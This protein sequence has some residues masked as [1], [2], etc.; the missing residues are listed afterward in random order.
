MN[1]IGERNGSSGQLGASWDVSNFDNWTSSDFPLGAAVL[2]AGNSL[3]YKTGGWRSDRPVWNAADCT[4]CM[5]CWVHCA[6]S[7]ILVAEQQMLGIDYDH[8]KGCGICALECRF[9]ALR[10]LPEAEAA[11]LLAASEAALELGEDAADQ[12]KEGGR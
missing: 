5:L 12:P 1:K 2:E 6:D 9:G 11:D 8:C 3:L 10:M 4:N 7:S